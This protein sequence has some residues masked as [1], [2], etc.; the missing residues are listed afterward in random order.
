M[1][2]QQRKARTWKAWATAPDDSFYVTRF[3]L[4]RWQARDDIA[5][6]QIPYHTKVRIIR[7]RITEILS[8][9]PRPQAP[10][11]APLHHVGARE[12]A[13]DLPRLAVPRP[14]RDLGVAAPRRGQR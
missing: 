3:F 10:E 13:A 4:E 9:P 11:A 6:S 2:P 14:L 5:K 12:K 1:K 7:V 8:K